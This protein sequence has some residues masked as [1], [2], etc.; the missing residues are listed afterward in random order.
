MR[1]SSLGFAYH[2]VLAAANRCSPDKIVLATV[3]PEAERV[4]NAVEEVALYG[5]RLGVE[6]S[7]VRLNPEDFWKCAGEA[8]SLFSEN[9]SYYLDIG[10]GVRARSL[11]LFAAALL[12][13]STRGWSW[14]TPWRS[15][16]RG[17]WRLT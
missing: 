13:S 4:K 7:V 12:P 14:S 10:G 16:R 2:H 17:W 3:N 6:V 5:R 8:A 1:V 15:T 11:C 9:A